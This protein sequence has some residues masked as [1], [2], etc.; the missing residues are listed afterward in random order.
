MIKVS[1]TNVVNYLS[2]NLL[3]NTVIS[4]Y[5]CYLE[6]FNNMHNSNNNQ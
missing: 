2:S 4:E 1:C 6:R 5:K 3:R